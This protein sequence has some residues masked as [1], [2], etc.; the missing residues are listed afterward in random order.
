MGRLAKFVALSDGYQ[1]EV[2]QP[3]G[4]TSYVHS[5]QAVPLGAQMVELHVVLEDGTERDYTACGS[6][7][8]MWLPDDE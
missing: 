7:L 4:P 1:I 6:Y 3:L 8:I 5:I 2:G